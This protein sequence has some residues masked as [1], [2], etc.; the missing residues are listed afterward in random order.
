M[1]N[2]SLNKWFKWLHPPNPLLMARENQSHHLNL[3]LLQRLSI[4]LDV[5]SAMEYLHHNCPSLI[6]HCGLKP[7]NIL[8]DED[9]T[10]HVGDFGLA[11]ILSSIVPSE[12]QS[13]TLGLKGSNGY[14]PPEYGFGIN[15]STKGDVYSFGIFYRNEKQ[16]TKI[17]KKKQTQK[18]E[19]TTI[20]QRYTWFGNM[21]T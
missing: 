13:S 16:S 19:T 10:A 3:N 6:V 1:C 9:M 15:A 5:A 20:M 4:A 18:K 14:I 21:P 8:L 11:R 17:R 2:G 7:S 12:H